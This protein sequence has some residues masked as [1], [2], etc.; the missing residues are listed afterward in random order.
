MSKDIPSDFLLQVEKIKKYVIFK[1]KNS[2]L[3]YL[4]NIG[5][6]RLSRY[7]KNLL[8]AT[9]SKQPLY[10]LLDL[11][12][13][14]K[15]L[16]FL[17][18]EYCKKIEIKLKSYISNYIS[19]EQTTGDFYL[20]SNSYTATK[21]ERNKIRRNRNVRNFEKFFKELQDKEREMRKRV[22]LYP[23]F[24]IYGN[25]GDRNGMKIPSWAFFNYIEFGTVVTL[26]SYL[27]LK[28]K[29]L[30]LK[31]KYPLINSSVGSNYLYSWLK[32]VNLIRNYCAHHNMIIYKNMFQSEIDTLNE[33]EN[34]LESTQDLFSSLYALR[35]ILSEEESIKLY[36]ELK[37]LIKKS[38]IDVVKYKILPR[39]WEEK[40]FK[41]V[42]VHI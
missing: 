33:K 17:L 3:P 12:N 10:V 24:S 23:D 5:Y 35:K 25:L 7:G 26:Y 28:Y 16:R 4:Y 36:K 38:K 14:D 15:N 6:Y 40:Y 41:I 29:K 21:G 32:R 1:N 8:R 18:F 34:L 11:Y 31:N 9:N 39:D 37:E 22:D 19:L 2:I 42:V 30:I 27:N 20:D 13:F